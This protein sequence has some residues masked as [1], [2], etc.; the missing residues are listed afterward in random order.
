MEIPLIQTGENPLIRIKADADVIIKGKDEEPF[1]VKSSSPEDV[2]VDQDGSTVNIRTTAEIQ[3]RVPRGASVEVERCTGNLILKGYDGSTTIDRVDGN[4]VVKSIGSLKV[5]RVSGDLQGKNIE[6]MTEIGSVDGNLSLRNLEDLQ[7]TGRVSGNVAL[8][9]IDGDA[10]GRSDGNIT[11]RL[12]PQPGSVYDFSASGN[13]VCRLP[14]DTGANLSIPRAGGRVRVK[15]GEVDISR[16]GGRDIVAGMG[17]ADSQL[18]LTADGTLMVLGQAPEWDLSKDFDADF[19]EEF[20]G[21]ADEISSHA[22]EQVEAQM[23]ALSAHLEAQLSHLNETLGASGISAEAAARISERAREASVRATEKAQEKMRQ[24]QERIRR[25]MEQAQRKAEQRARR[26]E[27]RYR[28][29]ERRFAGRSWSYDS[30]SVAAKPPSDPVSDEER[31]TIL[32]MLADKKIGMEE[33]EKL[34]SA[35]E[36]DSE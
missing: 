20:E 8:A 17:D 7:I 32:K 19:G 27:S 6:G 1:S 25:K 10:S 11:L 3:V 36:G 29:E 9:D 23:E 12:D 5:N 33:A 18:I 4:M 26:E 24:A 15:V 34:L 31:M 16:E 21:M 13:L 14:E 28:R 2:R 30:S 35:L 22:V